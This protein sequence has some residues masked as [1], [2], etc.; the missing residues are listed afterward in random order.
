RL[1][2]NDWQT[3]AIPWER[4]VNPAELTHLLG[5]RWHG[6]YGMA[7][8]PAHDDRNPSLSI[9]EGKDGQVLVNCFAGCSPKTGIAA[10]HNLGLRPTKPYLPAGALDQALIRQRTALRERREAQ[11]A[12]FI[13]QTWQQAWEAASP[14][15][16]SP[17][18]TGWLPARGINPSCLDLDRLPL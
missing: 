11:R 16:G 4:A 6:W 14:A 18:E 2:Q 1:G 17:I 10:L 8:C 7:K 15:R 9:G 3:A 13:E 12:A 5:G